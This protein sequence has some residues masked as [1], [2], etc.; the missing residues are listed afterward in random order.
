MRLARYALGFTALL[1]FQ[2]TWLE[3]MAIGGVKPDLVLITVFL[4][5]LLGGEVRG[6]LAGLILGYFMDLLSGGVWAVH[7]GIKALVG[8][9]AGLLGRSLVN[10]STVFTAAGIALASLGQ[11]IVFLLIFPFSL[12]PERISFYLTHMILPQAVYDGALGC[13]AFWVLTRGYQRRKDATQ[14]LLKD[15]LFL[16]SGRGR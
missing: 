10:V 11:G 9:I 6:T 2:T 13:A 15:G 12:G 16:S 14:R 5:G 1:L 8:F 7:L 4:L 3:K